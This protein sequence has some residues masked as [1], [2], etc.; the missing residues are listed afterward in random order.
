MNFYLARHILTGAERNRS[1]GISTAP[2]ARRQ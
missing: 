2:Y 1:L